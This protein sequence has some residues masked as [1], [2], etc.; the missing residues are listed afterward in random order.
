MRLGASFKSSLHQEVSREIGR[1]Q[2]VWYLEGLARSHTPSHSDS[3]VI[4]WPR[5]SWGKS[6]L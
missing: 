2:L 6:L 1:C 5:T 4:S 3:A